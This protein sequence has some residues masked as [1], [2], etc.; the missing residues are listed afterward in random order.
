MATG[1]FLG[2]LPPGSRGEVA[3]LGVPFDGTSS[4]RPGARFGPGAI[5]E[6]SHSLE[7][8][9]PFLDRDLRGLDYVDLGD[10]EVA[11]GAAERMVDQVTERVGEVLSEG[12]KP[13]VL[14]GEHTV[15]LG[16]LRALADHYPDLAL[17]QLDAHA[18]FRDEYLGERLCHATVMR[19]VLDYLPTERLFR[20]G[21]RSGTREELVGSGLEL[22][23]GFEGGMRDVEGLVRSLPS[24]A[25]LYV[26]LDLDVF[27]PSLVPGVGNPEPYGLTYRE[28][29]QLVR[30]LSWHNLVGF[31]VMELAPQYDPTGVSSVVA[32]SAVREWLLY[33]M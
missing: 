27:D 18:D 11:P 15:T 17:L 13:V 23:L 16:V 12:M 10:T 25:P 8:Y 20:L 19:R 3:L 24:D 26:T 14:G 29:I 33:M 4:F 1:G 22:P 32:A 30:G 7:T 31:D 28:F 6:G 2:S 9:G 5:R 21:V